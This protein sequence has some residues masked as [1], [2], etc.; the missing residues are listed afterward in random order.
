MHHALQTT[1]AV[2]FDFDGVLADSEPLHMRAI[3]SVAAT[4]GWS[5]SHEQFMR[6]IGKGDPHAFELLATANGKP[7]IATEIASMVECKTELCME[8][9]AAGDFT[10]QPGAAELV[11]ATSA[12]GPTG[13]CSGS[14]RTFVEGMLTRMGLLALLQTVVGHED[15]THTK[16]DPEPYLLAAKRLQV[17]PSRCIVIEDSPTG[18]R[19]AK[20][21]GMHVI[22]VGHSFAREHL[23]E[24]DEYVERIAELL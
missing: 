16:P 12:R 20:A 9:I 13:V 3:A 21:A 22:A 4:R 5:V 19:S 23:T 7:V 8:G 6:M 11:R 24:A 10:I 17:L 14:R 2:I 1:D 15:V 18:I